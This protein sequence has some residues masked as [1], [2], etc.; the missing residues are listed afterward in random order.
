MPDRPIH[1]TQQATLSLDSLEFDPDNPRLPNWVAKNDEAIYE[2]ITQNYTIGELV[3]SFI[4]N[5]YFE[6]ERLIVIP[7]QSISDRYIVVEGNRRLA[8]LK[9]L[10]DQLNDTLLPDT[11]VSEPRRSE[12]TAI[13]CL[14]VESREEVNT[15]LAYRHIGGMKTWSAEAKARFILRMIDSLI[16]DDD[17]H[18]FRTIGRKVGSNAYGIRNLYIAIA[19]LEHAR[20]EL[21]LD[22]DYLQYKRFGVWTRCMNSSEIREFIGLG[23]PK[24]YSEIVD[25][26]ANLHN[27]KLQEVIEDLS[28][29]PHHPTPVVNDSRLVTTYGRVLN[30][31]NAY[32]V[33]RDHKSLQAA[34][35][36]LEEQDMARRILTIEDQI[37]IVLDDIREFD[38]D[39]EVAKEIQQPTRKLL[40]SARMLHFTIA[41]TIDEDNL[42]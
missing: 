18:P 4:D 41:G 23:D 39:K 35:I 17:Q 34:I 30:H 38:L 12:L 14:I 24:N 32:R 36:V 33:L 2:H 3:D 5:G 25:R 19:V 10:Q 37:S 40:Q 15:Y 26:I 31:T 29:G 21:D 8:A 1:H 20:D 28:I 9:Y 22:V 6:A 42:V 27:D 13:P 7:S 16:A 11:I